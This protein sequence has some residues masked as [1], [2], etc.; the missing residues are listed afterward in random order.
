MNHVHIPDWLAA[1]FGGKFGM[2]D[3]AKRLLIRRCLKVR[4]LAHR[5]RR[6]RIARHWIRQDLA[7]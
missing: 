4:T 3:A 1:A 2:N 6:T 7:R 5:K